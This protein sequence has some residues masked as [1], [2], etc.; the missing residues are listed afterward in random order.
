M[1]RS[2]NFTLAVAG[3][4]LSVSFASACRST[5]G[6]GSPLPFEGDPL[7]HLGGHHRAITSL[8]PDA[9]RWFDKGLVLAYAFN[10]DEAI[11]CYQ[12][13]LE[14]DPECAIAYWGIAYCNG[15][16]INFPMVDDEHAR[17]ASEALTKAKELA[18]RAAPVERALIQAL[19]ARYA[20]PN[21]ADRTALDQTYANAMREV[22]RAYPRDTDV[23]ALFAESLMDLAPW[24][25]WKRDGEANPGTQE[26]LDT[27]ERVLALDARH[28][29]ANHLNIHAREA[30]QHPEGALASADALR[31]IVPGAGHLVHMPAHIY[32][33]VGRWHD[34][35]TAN[36]AGQAV[37]AAYVARH[38]EQGFY[39]AY[40]AHNPHF[41]AYGCMLEG[42]S[43]D[44]L[45][46]ARAVIDGMPAS[47]VEAN[48]PFVD[49]FLTIELE[50][51][52]RFGR[53]Q[54]ILEV[55]EPRPEVPITRLFRTFTRGI[56]H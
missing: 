16:H 41:L 27:L 18:P 13:A 2:P 6:G 49:A 28:P 52:M 38:A 7:D 31:T 8:S 3:L 53:W 56:G 5:A 11:R 48:A 35:S 33:R 4:A 51:L 23:G 47:F 25:Q 10:H 24:N 12:R 19:D 54:A 15:P 46:A 34:S 36:E 17:R 22:W 30:S 32:A 26:I 9:G 43:A 14:F 37:D 29:L 42:R 21:P 39:R 40:M 55:P 1:Q 20:M 44:A 50:V 45:R